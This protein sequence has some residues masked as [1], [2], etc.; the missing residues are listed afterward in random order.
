MITED[1]VTA[2][3]GLGPEQKFC[4]IERLARERLADAREQ[5]PLR[6]AYNDRS[7]PRY[8]EHDYA[9]HVSAAANEFGIHELANFELPWPSDETSE[10][11]CRMYR[12]RATQVSQQLMYRHGT[13]NAT[14]SLDTG[15]KEKISHWLKQIRDVVQAAEIPSDKKDRLFA[16]VN[17][18]QAEVDRERTPVHAGGELFVTICTYAGDGL[19]KALEPITPYIERIYGVIGRAK[20]AED[21]QP[22]Q[23]PPAREAKRIEGPKAKTEK[24]GNGFSKALDDEIP[25]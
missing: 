7:E 4:M 16:L 1:D 2:L 24:K 25:F 18:L 8:S 15:T 22:R 21:S 10:Q 9:V 20:N 23:L 3:A 11:S 19:K 17:E 6:S 12:A 14:V 13:K 5:V